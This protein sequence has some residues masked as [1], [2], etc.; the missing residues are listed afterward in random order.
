MNFA[1]IE[2][3][4]QA[5]QRNGDVEFDYKD[6]SYTIEA[7]RD[8]DG[9]R[10]LAIWTAYWDKENYCVYKEETFLEQLIEEEVVDKVLNAKCFDLCGDFKMQVLKSTA[11]PFESKNSLAIFDG[12]SFLEIANDVELTFIMGQD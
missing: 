10:Y 3:V 2:E 7:G 5:L 4:Y 11:I 9:K 12:K 6:G 8:E 1:Q